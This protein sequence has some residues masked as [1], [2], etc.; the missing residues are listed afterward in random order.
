M[1]YDIYKMKGT[2]VNT[3]EILTGPGGKPIAKPAP[4]D[5]DN[6]IDFIR[7][8]NAWADAVTDTA[9]AAFDRAWHERKI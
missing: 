3:R 1:C 5:F 4:E 7:A 9:N 6:P 8:R 2:R